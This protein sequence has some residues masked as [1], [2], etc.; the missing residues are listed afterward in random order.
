M[1]NTTPKPW[2]LVQAVQARLQGISVANGYR[3]DLGAHVAVEAQQYEDTDQHLTI[4]TVGISPGK[5]NQRDRRVRE[6]QLSLEMSVPVVI[7]IDG[8][9]NDHATVHQAIADVEDALF[10]AGRIT[11]VGALEAYVGDISVIDR[12]NGLAY[13]AAALQLHV[14]YLP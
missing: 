2:L 11:V 9:A 1:A 8:V 7:G 14:E 3:T 6:L 4:Y 13:T 12:P 10:D 5:N